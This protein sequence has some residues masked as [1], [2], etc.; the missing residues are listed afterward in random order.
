MSTSKIG[1]T[2]LCGVDAIRMSMWM[3]SICTVTGVE[4]LKMWLFW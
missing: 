1:G 2:I 4:S 3:G